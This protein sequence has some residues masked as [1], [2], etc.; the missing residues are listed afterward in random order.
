MVLSC[1]PGLDATTLVAIGVDQP[2]VRLAF[3][4]SYDS[5]DEYAQAI[6][7]GARLEMWTDIPHRSRGAGEWGAIAFNAPAADDTT[8][9]AELTF[10][11]DS[12]RKPASTDN[13]SLQLEYDMRLP[14]WLATDRPARFSYTYRLRWPS[15]EVRWLGQFGRNGTILVE[16][17]DPR[18]ILG[19]GWVKRS[20]GSLTHTGEE[21]ADGTVEV[22]R[23][24]RELEW[25]YWTFGKSG[26]HRYTPGAK[27]QADILLCLPRAPAHWII[28]PQPLALAFSF[29]AEG[30]VSVSP[31]GSIIVAP[32]S[33]VSVRLGTPGHG[34]FFEEY[35]SSRFGGAFRKLA[36][37][38]SGDLLL[39]SVDEQAPVRVS[40][41]PLS[42]SNGKVSLPVRTIAGALKDDV[43]AGIMFY[44]DS[45]PSAKYVDASAMDSTIT[46]LAGGEF[47]VASVYGIEPN[48]SAGPQIALLTPHE[49]VEEPTV[50]PIA[51]L[52]SPPLTPPLTMTNLASYD[53]DIL[54]RVEP[55]SLTAAV[56][57]M[58]APA[59]PEPEPVQMEETPSI[60]EDETSVEASSASLRPRKDTEL[61]R[62]QYS[63]D[64]VRYFMFF[65]F[66]MTTRFFR[67]LFYQI[68]GPS[69]SAGRLLASLQF[70]SSRRVTT[71]TRAEPIQ[72]AE[73]E[74]VEE[75]LPPSLSLDT[76][77][78]ETEDQESEPEPVREPEVEQPEATE[79][80]EYTPRPRI[81]SIR[82]SSTPVLPKPIS[83]AV[84][85]SVSAAISFD[86][87]GE[88][89]L[90]I[91]SAPGHSQLRW[92]SVPLVYLSFK[93]NGKPVEMGENE[94]IDEGIWIVRFP[95][96]DSG[97]FSVHLK[98]DA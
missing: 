25:S 90:A 65:F 59:A 68:F 64:C 35:L 83:R 56:N 98:Q 80:P 19:D 34:A 31:S 85:A 10:S 63:R 48:G 52:P 72:Q 37:S 78:E 11:L 26:A 74:E 50:D 38:A 49:Q 57:E 13:S 9:K 18:F 94:E 58:L 5:Q 36:V 61:A 60:E 84:S 67:A 2:S 82:R 4:A 33:A 22:G 54:E 86:V 76:V 7:A 47:V 24:S 43:H 97:R 89:V 30:T 71:T 93:L 6:R 40:L 73:V 12:P 66:G 15:G 16:R 42:M 21:K 96:A 17:K 92:A 23:L 53:S 46:I 44:S 95:S 62:R 28:K 45:L 77:V 88:V 75:T 14:D 55:I 29:A 91:R 41:V 32:A 39:A 51:T 81:I 27:T 20:D 1:T 79:Q 87:K 3:T 70:G 8:N 69:R